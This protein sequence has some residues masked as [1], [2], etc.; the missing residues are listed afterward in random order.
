VV[1]RFGEGMAGAGIFR[2]GAGV[3]AAD[4]ADPD[5]LGGEGLGSRS[6]ANESAATH[7]TNTRSKDINPISMSDRDSGTQA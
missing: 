5:T 7:A 3:L 4:G 2:E 1:S 6:Q